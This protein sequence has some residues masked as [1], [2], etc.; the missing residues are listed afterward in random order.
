MNEN[1]VGRGRVSDLDEFERDF[2]RK[3]QEW[4]EQ[5]VDVASLEARIEE[6][7]AENGRLREAVAAFVAWLDSEDA[8]LDYNGMTRDT[9]PSGEFIWH[10]W[11]NGNLA[12]CDRALELG[13]AA[14]GGVDE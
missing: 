5:P 13:R 3:R 4:A 11:W 2:E 7:E 1:C 10:K 14:L 6:L 8:G 12:L 9:H